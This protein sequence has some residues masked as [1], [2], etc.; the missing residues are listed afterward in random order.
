MPD[1][2]CI[3]ETSGCGKQVAAN[4]TYGLIYTEV[5]K[6]AKKYQQDSCSDE[7]VM[8]NVCLR[9]FFVWGGGCNIWEIFLLCYLVSVFEFRDVLI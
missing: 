4:E 9:E 8:H 1:S 3:E 2:C 6:I 5:C 7:N